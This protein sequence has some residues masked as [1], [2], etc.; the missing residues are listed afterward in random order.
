MSVKLQHFVVPSAHTTRCKEL[1][2]NLLKQHIH[3]LSAPPTTSCSAK[4]RRQTEWEQVNKTAT[5]LQSLIELIS[6]EWLMISSSVHQGKSY[7]NMS[8]HGVYWNM[9][10]NCIHCEGTL[11]YRYYN[12]LLSVRRQTAHYIAWHWSVKCQWES[13]TAGFLGF[14]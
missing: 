2:R 4:N 11:H 10:A 5:H 9:Y 12:G 13:S 1:Y 8:K 3:Q 7:T 14:L 6:K